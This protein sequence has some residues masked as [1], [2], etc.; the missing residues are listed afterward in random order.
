MYGSMWSCPPQLR[1]QTNARGHLLHGMIFFHGGD[2]SEL[3]AGKK[4]WKRTKR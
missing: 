4:R 3:V 1:M 2:E